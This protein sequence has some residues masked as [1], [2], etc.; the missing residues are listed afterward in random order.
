[1]KTY[2]PICLPNQGG[3][4]THVQRRESGRT[5]TGIH[6]TNRTAHHK[7]K[8]AKLARNVWGGTA[9]DFMF[10]IPPNAMS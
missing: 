9:G 8:G 1:M 5:T 7:T 4:Q 10:K 3:I 6:A 2:I